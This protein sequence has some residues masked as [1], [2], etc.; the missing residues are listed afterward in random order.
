MDLQLKG[1]TAV[2]IG[3]AS[4]IGLATAKE[5]ANEGARVWGADVNPDIEAT[6]QNEVSQGEG[7]VVDVTIITIMVLEHFLNGP[8]CLGIW[9]ICTHVLA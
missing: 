7:F 1:Q 4:G 9:L 6:M 2:I 8:D 5:F 3:A